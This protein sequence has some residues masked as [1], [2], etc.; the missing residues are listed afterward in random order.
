MTVGAKDGEKDEETK[1]KSEIGN[2]LTSKLVERRRNGDCVLQRLLG[3]W[4]VRKRGGGGR[5]G[6]RG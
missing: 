4:H 2:H 3:T 1:M 6:G 5:K